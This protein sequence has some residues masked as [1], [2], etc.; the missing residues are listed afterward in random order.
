MKE[1]YGGDRIYS[2][3]SQDSMPL[4]AFYKLNVPGEFRLGRDATDYELPSKLEVTP[5][6]R[7]AHR[8]LRVGRALHRQRCPHNGWP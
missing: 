8:L 2:W 3:K 4:S 6:P 7:K 5:P 1:E